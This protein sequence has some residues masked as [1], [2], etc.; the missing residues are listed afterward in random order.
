MIE[1]TNQA[2]EPATIMRRG[3]LM[4]GMALP[5]TDALPPNLSR[6]PSLLQHLPG[7]SLRQAFVGL[8]ARSG[9]NQAVQQVIGQSVQR[10]GGAG[11]APTAGGDADTPKL[12]WPQIEALMKKSARGNE[13]LQ[14]KD[15]HTVP[16]DLATTG[17]PAYFLPDKGRCVVN[18]TLPGPE[19]V[20]YLVHEMH[21][22][23]QFKEGKSPDAAGQDEVAWVAL[24]VQ[25][26][27]DGTIK[28]FEAKLE[29]E[30]NGSAPK[31]DSPPQMTRYR[32]AYDY[33]RKVALGED[34]A[35]AAAH[36]AGLANGRRMTRYLIKPGDGTWPSL[37]PNKLESYEMYYRR[38]W[39]QK[40]LP[41][42]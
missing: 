2:P 40:N 12:D 39:R 10:H 8:L 9:G 35:E 17:P 41:K 5:A 28:G 38:E 22:A 13:A 3:H 21:H 31:N 20:A 27:I 26:E 30:K 25:E 6:L 4:P 15:Q 14:I 37:A 24:M 19:V 23:K 16:V 18:V 33:A 34:K 29:M 1:R 36:A 11:E 32:S 7:R 42:R